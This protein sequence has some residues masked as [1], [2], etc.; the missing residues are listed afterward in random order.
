MQQ[1]SERAPTCCYC[2]TSRASDTCGT[3]GTCDTCETCEPH[4]A[5]DTCDTWYTCNHVHTLCWEGGR[6]ALSQAGGPTCLL[7]ILPNENNTGAPLLTS[8]DAAWQV[9]ARAP[10]CYSCATCHTCNQV[11]QCCVANTTYGMVAL[12]AISPAQLNR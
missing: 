10:S 3:R 5:C 2:G 7:C 9:S 4:R 11:H 12:W 1:T 8:T 6:E